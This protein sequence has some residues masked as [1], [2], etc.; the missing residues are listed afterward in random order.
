M[1]KLEL[2]EVDMSG[3][4]KRIREWQGPALFSY[5]FRPFFLLGAIWAALA[6]LIW[7]AHLAGLLSLPFAS[8][9]HGHAL[10]FGFGAAAVGGFVLTAVPNW[11]GRLPVTGWPLAGLVGLWLAGRLLTA[12]ETGPV[13]A[14]VD[15]ALPV[16][17]VAMLAREVIRGRNWRNLPVVALIATFGLGLIL[18]H[19][20][21]PALGLRLGLAALVMLMALIGGRI[22]P[23]FT[24]N[25]LVK[26]GSDRLPVPFARLDKVVVAASAVALLGFVAAPDA[27]LTALICGLVGLAHI[28][29]LA[30]WQGVQTGPEPLLWILHLA[31]LWVALGFLSVA[32]A[33]LGLMPETGARHAWMA[34]AVGVMTLAVMARASLGHTGREL[35]AGAGLTAVFVAVNI[36]AVARLVQALLPGQAWLLHLAATAW[37]LAFA[38]FALL[39]WPVLTGP[40]L[41]AQQ[42]NR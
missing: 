4:A 25:W 12:F 15:M 23:S 26:R 1:G 19:L 24:R 38:G 16:V 29:R 30:R 5:G 6:M 10:I 35:H 33:G 41:Q 9:W 14:A 31:Y 13:G 28:A 34:G 7:V 42:P 21:D 32:G 20:A 8:L 3:N 2:G 22:I 11:T 17:L 39:F 27:R 36:A 37:I 18:F 40:R